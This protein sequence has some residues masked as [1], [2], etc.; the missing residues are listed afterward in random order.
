MPKRNAVISKIVSSEVAPARLTTSQL[1][2]IKITAIAAKKPVATCFVDWF[3]KL[4]FPE[5]N[6]IFNALLLRNNLIMFF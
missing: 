5:S 1:D 4:Y 6:L 2:Q 3:N